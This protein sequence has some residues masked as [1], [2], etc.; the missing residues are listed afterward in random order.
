MR[1]GWGIFLRRGPLRFWIAWRLRTLIIVILLVF[2]IIKI[3]V[4]L[5]LLK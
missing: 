3:I 4:S 1:A 5:A 2:G